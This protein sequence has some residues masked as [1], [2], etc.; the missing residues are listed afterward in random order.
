[1]TKE[2]INMLKK[3]PMAHLLSIISG[4]SV[5]EVVKKFEEETN[6]ES[7]I[8]SDVSDDCEVTDPLNVAEFKQLIYRIQDY[9]RSSYKYHDVGINLEQNELWNKSLSIIED[10]LE[11]IFDEEIASSIISECSDVSKDPDTCAYNVIDFINTCNE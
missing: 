5:D 9:F 8:T 10:L 3:D 4:T 1:M 7:I 6:S 2:E 11:I